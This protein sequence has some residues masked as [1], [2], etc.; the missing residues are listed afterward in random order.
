ML[1]A[2]NFINRLSLAGTPAA[3]TFSLTIWE[4]QR[5]SSCGIGVL[6][7]RAAKNKVA[8]SLLNRT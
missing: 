6:Q 3:G 2:M 5:R 4:Q 1:P 8:M 7:S